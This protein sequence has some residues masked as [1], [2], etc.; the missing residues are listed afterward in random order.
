MELDLSLA[1]MLLEKPHMLSKQ[2]TIRRKYPIEVISENEE[3]DLAILKIEGENTQGLKLGD[4]HKLVPKTEYYSRR[5]S[6]LSLWRYTL[7]SGR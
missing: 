3:I 7:H 5:I 6:K 2:M 1:S 4:L